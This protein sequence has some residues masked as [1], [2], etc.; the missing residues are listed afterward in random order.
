MSESRLVSFRVVVWLEFLKRS[1]LFKG[2]AILMGHR[3]V[4]IHL[5]LML[6]SVNALDLARR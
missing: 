6:D 5:A 1:L 2:F 3:L 4:T